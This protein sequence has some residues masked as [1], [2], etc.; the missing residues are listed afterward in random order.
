MNPLRWVVVVA[1]GIAAMF[2]LR[3]CVVIP[4]QCMTRVKFVEEQTKLA[5]AAR[6][7]LEAIVLAR[8]NIAVLRRCENHYP[9][10]VN[11][12]M[13]E[14]ANYQIMSQLPRASEAYEKALRI[15]RRPEIYFNLGI[16]ELEMKNRDR[17][18][19]N[20]MSAVTFAPKLLEEV[21]DITIREEVKAEIVKTF[22]E[23]WLR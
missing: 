5:L 9:L 13:L 22:G 10:D 21:P 4:A 8:E 23:D 2:A 6:T 17:A 7:G 16:V 3:S 18:R 11:V 19:T 1:I 15:D 20:F 12:Y 14:G